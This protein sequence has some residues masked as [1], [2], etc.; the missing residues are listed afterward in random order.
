MEI[1]TAYFQD[2]R[3]VIH[4]G[5]RRKFSGYKQKILEGTKFL[6]RLAFIFHLFHSKGG[7]T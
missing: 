7:A 3:H 1:R 2:F 4:T 6:D 5:T